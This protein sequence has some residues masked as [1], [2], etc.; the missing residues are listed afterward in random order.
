MEISKIFCKLGWHNWYYGC[1]QTGERSKFTGDHVGVSGRSCLD[2]DLKQERVK[3][4]NYKIVK[5][6]IKKDEDK[7][8]IIFNL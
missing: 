4:G 7:I 6:F 2:C 5:S 3:G 8:Q 1:F